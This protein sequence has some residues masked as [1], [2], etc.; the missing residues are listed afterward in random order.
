MRP[1]QNHDR[2]SS[3]DLAQNL[4]KAR[5]EFADPDGFHGRACKLKV[6]TNDECIRCNRI[7][8]LAREATPFI[9]TITSSGKF[10]QVK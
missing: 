7:V 2:L 5:L 9:F 6:L 8:R 3:L 10:S 4:G 1:E